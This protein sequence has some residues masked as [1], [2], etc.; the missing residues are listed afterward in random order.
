MYQKKN[1]EQ[2]RLGRN[3]RVRKYLLINIVSQGVD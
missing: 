2:N 1:L 3:N